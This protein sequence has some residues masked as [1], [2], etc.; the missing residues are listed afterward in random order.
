[1]QRVPLLR[2]YEEEVWLRTLLGRLWK[3]APFKFITVPHGFRSYAASDIGARCWY[4]CRMIILG[5]GLR[6]C[7]DLRQEMGRA[8]V[9]RAREIFDWKV[10]AE[11]WA[12]VLDGISAPRSREINLDG[13]RERVVS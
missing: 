6:Q 10:I 13:L 3:F 7:P 2:R 11:E 9:N 12:R 1:M 8:D 4:I 5:I